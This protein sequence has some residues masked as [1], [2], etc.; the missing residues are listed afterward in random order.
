MNDVG[1][2]ANGPLRNV[3]NTPYEQ[4]WSFDIERQLPA[5]ILLSTMYVG[6]K[7]THL[8][9]AGA[10]GLNHLGSE[11]EGYSSSEIGDLTS[12]V[13]NPFYGT[14]TNENSYL[15]AEQVA[16]YMLQIPY[17]QFPDG[18]TVEPPP[19]ANS[20]YHSLQVSADKRYSNGLQFLTTFVWSKS[21]DDSSVQDDNTTWLGSF[22]SLQNPNKPSGERSLSSFDLPLVLQLTYLYDLPLGRGKALFGNMPRVLDAVVGGWKTNGV[23]RI[24]SGRP[25]CMTLADGTSLPTYGSQ[26]PNIVGK[27]KRTHGKDST[28]YNN[29]FANPDVFK[30][31]APY[32]MGSAPRTTGLLRA[33]RSFTADMSAEKEFSLDEVRKGM[34]LELRLEAQNA[35]N[36]P[37]FGTPN[38]TVDGDSFGRIS[39]MSNGP[40]QV[41]LGAKVT[42]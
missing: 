9:F 24:S 16:K 11:I 20:T 14:I 36:H 32:V 7:G 12:K 34:K 19:I 42:F 41:Q 38:T 17:P 21:I 31:P 10:N 25:L 39:Y 26:R 40:R 3:T 30:K 29:Y 15:S 33:P 27:P 35:F 37:V 23:F 4:S 28:W 6:K 18:V 13:D 5:K 1:F 8:Y 22:T 2:G